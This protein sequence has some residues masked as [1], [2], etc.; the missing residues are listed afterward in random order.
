MG[1]RHSLIRHWSR[2]D[3]LTVVIIAVSAA[4]LVGTTVLLLTAG[5][6]LGG[7]TGD[8]STSATVTYHDSVSDAEN[9]RSDDAIVFPIAVVADETGAEHTVVG[10]PPDAPSDLEDDSS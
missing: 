9:V 7:I 6:Q 4:F 5:A 10:I 3:W 2:R 1:Y 8:V